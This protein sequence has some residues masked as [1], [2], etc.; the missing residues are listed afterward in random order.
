VFP[1]SPNNA[2]PEEAT[3]LIEALEMT[4]YLKENMSDEFIK[5]AEF[6]IEDNY[7]FIYKLKETS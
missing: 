7:I 5:A 3:P 2:F 4:K 1:F 6:G